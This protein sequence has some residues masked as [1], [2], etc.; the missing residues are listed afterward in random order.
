VTSRNVARLILMALLLANKDAEDVYTVWNVRFVGIIPN[1]PVYEINFLEMEFLQILQY[2]LHV[3]RVE[4]ER[5]YRK[6][7]TLL[8]EKSEAE[9]FEASATI[10]DAELLDPELMEASEHSDQAKEVVEPEET[11]G[12]ETEGSEAEEVLQLEADL[13]LLEL[14]GIT[15]DEEP[16]EESEESAFE[17]EDSVVDSEPWPL[18]REEVQLAALPEEEEEVDLQEDEDDMSETLSDLPEIP[19]DDLADGNNHTEFWPLEEDCYEE[20]NPT[21][22]DADLR[23]LSWYPCPV[24]FRPGRQS[25]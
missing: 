21:I 23:L 5:F 12:S 8:P 7:L 24:A 16:T 18:S 6:L 11:E 22:K 2:R 17:S 15:E 1:L 25:E 4:Y 10:A 20:S 3:E 19:E 9:E 13:R 14:E